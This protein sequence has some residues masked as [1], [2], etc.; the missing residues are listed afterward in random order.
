[1]K[2]TTILLLIILS[3]HIQGQTYYT[4]PITGTKAYM[5]LA[6]KAVLEIEFANGNS[7]LQIQKPLIVVED[8]DSGLM[9]KENEFGE[10]DYEKFKRSIDN[11]LS[12]NLSDQ[13]STYDI[14]YVN[15]KNGH[16]YM[17]RN[18]YLVEDIIKWVNGQKAISGSTKKNVV[19]G[20]GM[21]GL[22][23]RYALKDMENN[24]E[25][26]KTSLYIS[27]DAPHQGA[28]V[29]LAV[30]YFLR[31]VANEKVQ[32]N[33]G[34][35]NV[36]AVDGGISANTDDL[37]NLFE[38]PG[39]QQ[40]MINYVNS[41]FV[42]D[43]PKGTA[44]REELKNLGYPQ[45]RNIAISNGSHCANTQP[46]EPSDNLFSLTAHVKTTFLADLLMAITPI[47]RFSTGH[48]NP[49][50]I[51]ELEGRNHFDANFYGKALPVEWSSGQVYHG[52]MSYKKR[53][54]LIPLKTINLITPR[55]FSVPSGLSYDYYPGGQKELFTDPISGSVN[56]KDSW[57]S[58]FVST[59]ATLQ[60]QNSFDYIPTP[61]G[62]DVGS[63]QT[64][65]SS[66][67][68]SEKYNKLNPPFAS[69]FPAFH[70]YT[71]SFN[72]SGTNENH[73]SFNTRNGDWLATELDNDADNTQNFDCTYV[74]EGIEIAGP[75]VICSSEV[76][77]YSSPSWATGANWSIIQGA[78]L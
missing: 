47:I 52:S 46:F 44:W 25:D 23:A 50:D 34:D 63:G 13:L 65:L 74:C 67:D 8:F 28:N 14:I 42:N 77:S 22:I 75:D 15:F 32:G 16:D 4:Q 27:H 51:K 19:L 9:G 37:S 59:G 55:D 64:S 61:S 53:F 57:V 69:K 40:L 70:N 20:Q 68:F 33:L 10:V 71:T 66:N 12:S 39:T 45:I 30:Q 54:W 60:I 72:T 41:N 49:E 11:G 31:H 43:N 18:A 62:L 7:S 35:I 73:I 26:H 21:G 56:N 1:M 3:T 38:Q 48:I 78:N 24:Y 76:Y 29:P 6:N 36:N 58:Y 2:K 17:Q 5:G